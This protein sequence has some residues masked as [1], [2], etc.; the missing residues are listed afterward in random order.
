MKKLFSR[1]RIA[2]FALVAVMMLCLSGMAL[3]GNVTPAAA[4]TGTY[5]VNYYDYYNQGTILF[6][7]TATVGEDYTLKTAEELG[8]TTR[9]GYVWAW[10]I[11]SD[12]IPVNYT[13]GQTIQGG[14]SQTDGGTVNLYGFE[15]ATYTVKFYGFNDEVV[16]TIPDNISRTPFTFP[17]AE[18]AGI[19]ATKNYTFGWANTPA[20]TDIKYLGGETYSLVS[21]PTHEEFGFYATE[22]PLYSVKY[23]K[24]SSVSVTIDETRDYLH[25]EDYTYPTAEEMNVEVP[26]GSVFGWKAQSWGSSQI[27]WY[28]GQTIIGGIDTSI[29]TTVSRYAVIEDVDTAIARFLGYLNTTIDK[30]S[31][32]THTADII[33]FSMQLVERID[34]CTYLLDNY[35]E[36]MATDEQ[37]ANAVEMKSRIDFGRKYIETLS[38]NVVG[39]IEQ[40]IDEI[41]T[42]D[43]S[44][45]DFS[46]GIEAIV[47]K[48]AEL[49]S[50]VTDSEL[51]EILN[52]YITSA[53]LTEILSG[54]VTEAVL[55]EILNDYVTGTALETALAEYVSDS[56]LTAILDQYATITYVDGKITSA[57]EA[58]KTELGQAIDKV[59]QDLQSARTELDAAIAGKASTAEVQAA[60]DKLEQEY[61]AADAMIEADISSL[62]TLAAGLEAKI[63]ELNSAYKAADN[64]IWAAINKLQSDY[65]DLENRVEQLEQGDGQTTDGEANSSLVITAG[66][67]G[68]AVLLSIAGICIALGLKRNY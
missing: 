18:E 37:K 46:D 10:S 49:D 7:D 45:D 13:D 50:Y 2:L 47:A 26:T 31:T 3:L 4:Q 8:Q 15:E 54:Y 35:V 55:D 63:D 32:S 40:A 43:P 33:T 28:G 59:A 29:G 65:E 61:K 11:Y 42:L 36:S 1:T 67:A 30:L 23:G 57:I 25:G 21:A 16:L 5:T 66:I 38:M 51:T 24:T 62:E 60:L 44:A 14:L 17:T 64:A 9:E 56:D 39:E 41:K 34:I 58:A 68:V 6:T 20:R 12:R 27:S 53:A 52:S 22:L 19:T 48:L